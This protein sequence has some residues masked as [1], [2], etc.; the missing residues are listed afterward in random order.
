MPVLLKNIVGKKNGTKR[1]DL[2]DIKLFVLNHSQTN[3]PK[4]Y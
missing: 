1:C 3:G 4:K 2:Y